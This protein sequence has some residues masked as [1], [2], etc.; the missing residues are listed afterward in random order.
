MNWENLIVGHGIEA[1]D[2]LLANPYNFRVHPNTQKQ[3]MR[4]VLQTVGIVDEVIV[5]ETTG[6][7][8]NGHLRVKIALEDGIEEIPVK[9]VRMS[10]EKELLVLLTF[11]PVSAMAVHDKEMIND[12]VN[13]YPDELD[14][15]VKKIVK[16]ALDEDPGF[17]NMD[18]EQTESEITDKR[19]VRCPKC[20]FKF[21]VEDD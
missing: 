4:K 8:V 15:D 6:H 14:E 5:N 17:I 9:Y 2:Q 19:L 3:A 12:I 13:E 10:L 21:G 18:E 20:G 11:D 16:S 1:P 7:V